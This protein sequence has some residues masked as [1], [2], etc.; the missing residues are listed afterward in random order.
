MGNQKNRVEIS[1]LSDDELDYLKALAKNE[2]SSSFNQFLL[3]MCREKIQYGQFNRT[4][5]LYLASLTQMAETTAFLR[6][7][8]DKKQDQ[9]KQ[10]NDRLKKINGHISKWL[11][12]EGMIEPVSNEL[13]Q[14]REEELLLAGDFDAL[15]DL[16]LEDMD[17]G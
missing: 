2:R 17:H 3:K 7:Q 1:G 4:E 12:Y 16:L 6:Q 10:M 14:K 15:Q 8:W 5:H 13:R 9:L 11:E